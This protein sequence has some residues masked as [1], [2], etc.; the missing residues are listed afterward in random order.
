MALIWHVI[1]QTMGSVCERTGH[2]RPITQG[3]R[4]FARFTIMFSIS[5][6][7][8]EIIGKGRIDLANEDHG[9]PVTTKGT[10]N[11]E[12]VREN[13][14]LGVPPRETG[15]LQSSKVQRIHE[16]VGRR[17]RKT[18]IHLGLNGAKSS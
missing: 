18:D 16:D 9:E 3:P 12:G 10:R 2:P 15:E 7:F 6:E 17:R 5:W 14:A 8:A 11:P 13:K 4:I 1:L